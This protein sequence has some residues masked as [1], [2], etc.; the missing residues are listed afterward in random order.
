MSIRRSLACR[1]RGTCA[2]LSLAALAALTAC[3]GG[4]YIAFWDDGDDA[5]PTVSLTASPQSAVP[6]QTI[7]LL[8]TASDDSGI[9]SVV[10]YRVEDGGNGSTRLARVCCAP[11]R[12][13][14]PLP[15]TTRGS[16]GYFARA[17]DFAGNVTQSD[18][19]AVD[20]A[21]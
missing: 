12:W 11:Y 8:A 13:T 7:T 16:V 9:D 19:V 21:L 15:D 18:T 4:V 20:V 5:D 2:A 17:V 14:T 1:L 3:G 10:F 6:G